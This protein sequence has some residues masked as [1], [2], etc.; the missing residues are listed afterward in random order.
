MTTALP[1]VDRVPIL[2]YHSVSAS[3]PDWIAPFAVRPEVFDRHLDLIVASGCQ[4]FTV[5]EFVDRVRNGTGVPV[6]SVVVTFDDGF[7]DTAEV[8][9]PALA[10]RNMPATVYIT[11][12]PLRGARH[13]LRP[14]RMMTRSQL[15]DLERSGLEIGAHSETHRAMDLLDEVAVRQEIEGSKTCLED[16]LGHRVR[17]FAYPHGHHDPGVAA[18]V[19][20]GGFDSACAVKNAF[21]SRRDDRFALARLTVRASTTDEQLAQWLRG[22]GATMPPPR[23]R[24]RTRAWRQYRRVAAR[25]DDP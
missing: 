15:A 18:L 19:H 3:P 11:T 2:L 1:A 9:A 22:L 21:S 12:G 17:S 10:V 23:Q 20:Q 13:R 8:A 25:W 6:R 7:A 24:W 5:S 14:A 16:A 4:A